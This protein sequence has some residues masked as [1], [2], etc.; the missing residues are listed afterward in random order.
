MKKSTLLIAGL[1]ALGSTSMHADEGMWTL[2]NL[3]DAVYEQMVAE[4]FQLPENMLYGAP[5]A[6]SNS[7]INFSGFCSGVVVSPN[8]LVFTNHHC[9]FSAINALSTVE[10]DYMKD[11]FYA[12]S[13]AEE[14]PSKDLFVSFMKKQEDITPRVNKLIAGKNAEQT[15]AII[16]SLTNH[17]T[18]SI[19]TID[20]TLHISVDAFYEGNKYYATTYQDFQDVRRR[21]HRIGIDASIPCRAS[22]PAAH[23]LLQPAWNRRCR[24]PHH[25][26]CDRAGN[27][28]FEHGAAARSRVRLDDRDL[29]GH[30]AHDAIGDIGGPTP[31]EEAHGQPAQM[32][33]KGQAHRFR[34]GVGGDVRLPVVVLRGDEGDD[35]ARDAAGE[36]RPQPPGLERLARERSDEDG[37]RGDRAHERDRERQVGEGAGDRRARQAPVSLV[38]KAQKPLEPRLPL[39][40]GILVSIGA[41]GGHG[42]GR[43]SSGSGLRSHRLGRKGCSRRRRSDSRAADGA[44]APSERLLVAFPQE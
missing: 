38:R 12:K 9:G 26:R 34:F 23:E 25:E 31:V 27:D 10:H 6:I 44:D 16:D 41:C 14:L 30:I 28:A 11:G 43:S 39:A 19:K 36:H 32:L 20:K 35:E 37:K 4:G 3:P 8:G 42:C 33:G 7:V 29:R 18:D 17:L 21:L 5:N 2:Y 13:Y 40:R 15:E 22:A 24:R 1:L